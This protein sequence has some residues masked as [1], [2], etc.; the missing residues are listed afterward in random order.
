MHDEPQFLSADE[1]WSP[2]MRAFGAFWAARRAGRPMPARADFFAEEWGRWWSRMLL[3]RIEVLP[4]GRVFRM[5]Y[6]GDEVEYTDGGSKIGRALDEITPPSLLER[7]L[8]A[9]G[10]VADRGVPF[11]SIR[12]GIWQ[13]QHEVAFER[14]LLPLGPTGGPADH[15]LGMLLDHGMTADFRRVDLFSQTPDF[16]RQ[17]FAFCHVDPDSFA[18]LDVATPGKAIGAPVPT[19]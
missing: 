7:T 18:G 8:R 4:A 12:V 6:Q 10:S 5:V 1:I 9:Y 19:R 15:V 13:R 14:L 11:Y 2:R 16:D 17:S 3:Y